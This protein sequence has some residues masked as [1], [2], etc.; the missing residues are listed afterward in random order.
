MN[1][2]TL[3]EQV[4][5]TF[6]KPSITVYSEVGYQQKPVFGA[7]AAVNGSGFAANETVDLTWDLGT[8]GTFKA[9]IAATNSSGFFF[10]N[11]T[12]PSLPFGVLAHLTAHGRISGLSASFLVIKSP[13]IYANPTQGVIG[14]PVSLTGGG[15]GSNENVKILFQNIVVANAHTNTKG[16]FTSNFAVP[17]NAKIGFQN[18]GII[19]SGKISGVAANTFFNVEP[20]VY[21]QPNTGPGGTLIAH[22]SHFTPNGFVEILWVF[23]L[24][25]PAQAALAATPSSLAQR[26]FLRAEPSP[27]RLLLPSGLYP[28]RSTMCR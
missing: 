3:I 13:A 7:P 12:M 16:F 5:F 2:A 1:S 28:G 8:L 22:G 25:R 17:V 6:T 9:G 24:R 18:N 20:N 27:P 26:M 23:S 11:F 21:I 19:A 15:F 14:A 4:L 10:S